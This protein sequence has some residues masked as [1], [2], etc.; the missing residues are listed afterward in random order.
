MAFEYSRNIVDL[1]KEVS[2]A[3]AGA[4]ANTPAI[5]L[6]QTIGGNIEGI[7]GQIEI[8]AVAGLTD[9]KVFSFVLQD[10]ADGT[11]FA[12]VDPGVS[13]TTTGAG[14]GGSPAKDARFRFPP[15][16]R[17]YVRI[18]QTVTATPGTITGDLKFRLLF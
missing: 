1:D 18:A 9:A 5:D 10:S 12:A 4:G 14:G 15:G 11:N 8:P 13:T 2:V 17:R 3:L 6:E 7:V 16:T